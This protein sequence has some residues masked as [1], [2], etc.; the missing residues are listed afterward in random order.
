MLKNPVKFLPWLALLGVGIAIASL[1]FVNTQRQ[2][3]THDT[4]ETTRLIGQA[5]AHVENLTPAS[6]D[7]P[8]LRETIEGLKDTPYLASIWLFD[9]DGNILSSAGSTAFQGNAHQR[10]TAEMKRVLSSLPKGVLSP[11]QSMI[12]IT[13]SAIQAEG[14]HNDIY[15]QMVREVKDPSG[16]PVA[17]I[18]VAYDI[19]PT[20]GGPGTAYIIFLLLFVLG[21][22]VY[23]LSLPLW[24]YLDA[25]SRH[26]PAAL[27]AIFVLIGN[28]V[29]LITYLLVKTP[30]R[31]G[32]SK[33]SES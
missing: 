23:W 28:L 16:K 32:T 12:L 19:N 6:A 14:E 13:A 22:A 30:R 1:I 11:E 29:A 7:D 27:W 20:I 24:V 3:F 2:E 18:G 8:A 10:E 5:L 33:P 26:E 17:L 4:G 25:R 15:R 9:M 31:N 21:L